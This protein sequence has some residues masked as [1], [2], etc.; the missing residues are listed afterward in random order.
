M[1]LKVEYDEGLTTQE[2]VAKINH[3]ESPQVILWYIGI[4]GLKELGAQFY[5]NSLITP[6]YYQKKSATFWLVDLTAWGA[7]KDSR[8]A[9]TKC[10]NHAIKIESLL[11]N[12]IKCIKSSDIFGKIQAIT[13]SS[14]IQYFQKAL[15]RNFV[16]RASADVSNNDISINDLFKNGCCLLSKFSH[17]NANKSYSMLQYLEGCLLV[18]EIISKFLESSQERK[19]E[20]IFA[21]P[22][23]EI[24][25]Y[26]D[27]MN[28]FEKDLN[29]LLTSLHGSK[30]NDLNVTVNFLS[31]KY[32]EFAHHRPYNSPGKV[33]KKNELTAEVLCGNSLFQYGEN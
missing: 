25:Y 22:N 6:I 27:K 15:S 1:Y 14:I 5:R 20:L 28:Y 32:G 2:V 10:S 30:I 23:D 17:A 3:F 13:D 11:E 4:R 21:L 7:L 18:E 29:F 24:R 26:R 9:I 12:R 33:L 19:I 8:V 31:F 16:W